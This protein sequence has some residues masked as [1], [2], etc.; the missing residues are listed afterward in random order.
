MVVVFSNYLLTAFIY[1][2]FW[3]GNLL[4]SFQKANTLCLS[5]SVC[6]AAELLLRYIYY[7]VRWGEFTRVR[8]WRDIWNVWRLGGGREDASFVKGADA[9]VMAIVVAN[10]LR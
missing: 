10:I 4:T 2:N 7:K 1:S 3:N 9:T 8:K 5:T 6:L